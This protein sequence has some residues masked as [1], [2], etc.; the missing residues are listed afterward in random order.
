MLIEG[1]G[2]SSKICR[3]PP[4]F[5]NPSYAPDMYYHNSINFWC[6]KNLGLQRSSEDYFLEN[7]APKSSVIQIITVMP[8]VHVYT[9]GNGHIHIK[10]H[11]AVI[12]V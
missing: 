1:R 11:M 10:Q 12:Y 7:S 9:L 4:R 2:Y 5:K 3:S 8:R 6:K